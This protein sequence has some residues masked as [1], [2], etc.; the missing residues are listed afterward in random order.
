MADLV[1]VNVGLFVCYF[2]IYSSVKIYQRQGLDTG[3]HSMSGYLSLVF[4]VALFITGVVISTWL[5]FFKEPV[6]RAVLTSQTW[7]WVHIWLGYFSLLVGT[8]AITSGGMNYAYKQATNY[9][10]K[11]ATMA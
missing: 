3:F 10:L 7:A 9:K 2:T 5:R 1:H 8:T 11:K 6:W 4:T